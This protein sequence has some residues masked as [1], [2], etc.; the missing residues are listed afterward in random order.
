MSYSPY[1][2]YS[3]NVQGAKHLVIGDPKSFFS[4]YSIIRAAGLCPCHLDPSGQLLAAGADTCAVR[5]AVA[6]ACQL[7][8]CVLVAVDLLTSSQPSALSSFPLDMFQHVVVYSTETDAQ[9][10]V[11][12]CLEGREC[13][14]TLLQIT[15]PVTPTKR[16]EE[17]PRSQMRAVVEH[18]VFM[19][20]TAAASAFPLGE[21]PIVPAPDW[22]L[23]VSSSPER[24][25]KNRTA[26]YEGLL[27]LERSGAVIVERLM[28]RIDLVLSPSAALV[29]VLCEDEQPVRLNRDHFL[30]SFYILS[31]L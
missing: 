2:L 11:L 14:I 4:L 28:Q 9:Q 1:L 15:A 17:R 20:A 24:P 12:A 21:T 29:V 18:H 25:I 10:S 6:S 16:V 8:D 30:G 27:G 22:P 7:A 31:V 19:K 26:L 23:V 13:S 5:E 3:N